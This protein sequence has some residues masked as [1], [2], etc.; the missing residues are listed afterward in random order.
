MTLSHCSLA[1]LKLRITKTQLR[2]PKIIQHQQDDRLPVCLGRQ[3]S[4]LSK[5]RTRLGSTGWEACRPSQARMP[6]FRSLLLLAPAHWRICRV[7]S[8]GVGRI[9]A[10][11]NIHRHTRFQIGNSRSLPIYVDFCELRDREC[12]RCFRVAHR[13]CV[14]LHARYHWL[15]IRRGWRRLLFFTPA[16]SWTGH[17]ENKENRD[18]DEPDVLHRKSSSVE[19]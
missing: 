18:D 16:E 2:D 8:A 3:A 13:N 17:N 15:M 14:P 1:R 7:D 10:N 11:C 5:N 6:N 19:S 4:C 12:P 9:Q